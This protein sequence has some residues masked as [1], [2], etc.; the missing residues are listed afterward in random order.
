MDAWVEHEDPSQS[1]QYLAALL[2]SHVDLISRF[3]PDGTLTFVSPS[4]CEFFG[5]RPSA[6]IGT[7]IYDSVPVCTRA[8]LKQRFGRLSLRHPTVRGQNLNVTHAGER[9]LIDW[10]NTGIFGPDGEVIEIQAVG[11]DVT[12]QDATAAELDETRT[13]LQAIV[14]ATTAQI[15][16]YDAEQRLIWW[17]SDFEESF[18][19]ENDIPLQPGIT[20]EALLRQRMNALGTDDADIE[21]QVA[22]LIALQGTDGEYEYVSD[23]VQYLVRN[24]P[25][26]NGMTVVTVTDISKL[27]AAEAEIERRSLLLRSILDNTPQGLSVFGADHRLVMCN[28]PFKDM[29]PYEAT[30]FEPGLHAEA[31]VARSVADGYLGDGDPDELTTDYLRRLHDPRER[32]IHIPDGRVFDHRRKMLPDGGWVT[33]YTDITERNRLARKASYE[34]AHDA[35]TGLVNRREFESRLQRALDSS[36]EEGAT[37]ALVYFDLDQ[38]KVVNDT[39]GHAAGDELLRQ[40]AALL[41]KPLRKRDTFARL[42]GDEFGVLMEHCTLTQANRVTEDIRSAIADY[43]FY[44]E[45]QALQV[46]ASMGLVSVDRSSE[47][48]EELLRRADAACYAAKDAG[49]NRLHIYSETDSQL[50]QRRGEMQ[51]V[52]RIQQALDDDRFVLYQQP[53]I[54]LSDTSPGRSGLGFE[55]LLRL[56]TE[57]GEIVSPGAFLPAV[58]R[59]GLATKVDCWVIRQALSW[60]AGQPGLVAAISHCAV[61]LSGYSL[62]DQS[63]PAFVEEQLKES[64]FPPEKLCFEVTET[65]AIANVAAAGDMFGRLRAL[66]CT[67][68]LDDFGSGLSSFAYLKSLPVDY[69]KI[70]GAYVKDITTDP[71]NYAIA[72]SVNELGQATGKQTIAEFAENQETIDKLRELGVNYAQGYGI[73]APAPLSELARTYSQESA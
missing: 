26:E 27:K 22:A 45:E 18:N 7:N 72:K 60:L 36:H 71:V 44:W 21:R 63:M 66:G 14:D 53:I 62:T 69:L 3:T 65:A 20:R 48:I 31:L 35:L 57:D 33:T 38:F 67:F 2:H 58:E 17:N 51:W 37:H 32:E 19:A 73:A 15:V 34:A 24:R 8:A 25:A 68:A 43:R 6:L 59:Y 54:S 23:S 12:Q 61:N 70:D 10:A 64:G 29:F 1:A 16:V 52:S 39:K 4:Y 46:G 9:R 47:T 49:R 30:Y 28:E 42:G 40:L 41:R 55:L 11:R 56:R 50:L 13:L 5:Q